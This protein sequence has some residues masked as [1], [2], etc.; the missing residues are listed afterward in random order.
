VLEALDRPGGGARTEETIPGHRFDLHSVAHNM[1]N[2]TS[3][4]TE[5]ALDSAGLVYQEMDPFSVAVFADGRIVRFHRSIERTLESIAEVSPDEARRYEAFMDVAIPI[6]RMILPSVRGEITPRDV[7]I[8]LLNAAR[9]LRRG[10]ITAARDLLSPY[11][12]L[13]RR[14]LLS[15]RTRG[16]VAAFA[17]HAAVGPT[18]PGGALFAFWQAAYHLSGQWHAR[19][20]AQGLTD[21]LVRRLDRLGGELRCSARVVRIDAAGGRVR[22]V[23]V[24]GGERLPAAAALTAIN[25]QVALLELLDPPLN[26]RMRAELTAVRR[27]NVV[28]ALIHVAT[29]RL[30]PY[31]QGRDGDWNGLQS[32]VDRLDDLTNAWV[33]SDAG[34]LPDPLPLY[35]FT[36]SA[37]DDSLAPPGRHTVYLACPAAP[38]RLRG[39]W[40]SHREQFIERALQIVEERAPGFRTSIQGVATWT[41]SDMEQCERWPGGHPMH[42]DI[43]LDQLGPMRPTPSLAGH[44]TPVVGLYVSGAGT[45]PS[46]GIVGTPGRRASRALLRDWRR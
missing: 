36:S 9:V 18:L 30:P 4:P 10:A 22:G 6:V 19:G 11:D 25:P 43:A 24:E 8:R 7:P 3:I 14:H 2:M 38:S 27:G 17:A 28:Q 42:I 34:L 33:A 41:P 13:L 1:L 5:L 20:G 45:N 35:A 16:P 21:A 40:S 15:D 29:D 46:G 32:Y 39:G 31:A 44:R 26:D 37:L 23:V 12:S